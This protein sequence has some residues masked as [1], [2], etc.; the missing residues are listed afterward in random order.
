MNINSML[1]IILVPLIKHLHEFLLILGFYLVSPWLA[2]VAGLTVVLG[3]VYMLRAFQVMMLGSAP[4]TM[5][6]F[7]PLT[8]HEKTVLTILVVLVIAFGVYPDIILSISNPSVESL[9]QG[10]NR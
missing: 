8:T 6:N 1:T 2:A 7:A 9:L 10:L 3:A 4:S 5:Q